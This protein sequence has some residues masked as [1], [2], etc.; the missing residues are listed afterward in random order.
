[1]VVK[2]RRICLADDDPAILYSL[3][4]QLR[5]L[6]HDVPCV[7]RSGEELLELC[8]RHKPDLVITDI[9]MPG[10][11]GIQAAE[12]IWLRCN[13]PVILV[14]AYHEQE[15]LER[16]QADPVFGYL[17][18]PVDQADLETAIRVAM[19]RF[20][21]FESLVQESKQIRETLAERK[22]IER[23]KGIIIKRTGATE[24]QAATRLEALAEERGVKVARIAQ[25]IIDG[26]KM[27]AAD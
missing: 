16:A 26:D 23:A 2:P 8:E 4:K 10:M 27:M 21:A 12:Q 6:G 9:V 20:E 18:K 1:M 7:A 14:S 13:V 5:A 24:F 19:A 11:D 25:A 22:L 3:E 17:V 15:L